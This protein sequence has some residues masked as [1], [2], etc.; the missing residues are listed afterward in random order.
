MIHGDGGHAKVVRELVF[1]P[2]DGWI[3]AV[4]DNGTR[5]KESRNYTHFAVAQ[6]KTAVISPSATIG[7]GTVVMAGAIVQAGAVI[8]KHVILNTNCSVDHDCLIE[9]FAHIAPGVH[10]CG[11]VHVGEGALVG[12]GSCAVPMAR[13]SPW[14]MIPAGSVVK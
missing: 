14:I 9:D 4:G 3:I 6:H 1:T 5:Q 13:V 11:G 2:P 10:L 8:G 7:E 12:V